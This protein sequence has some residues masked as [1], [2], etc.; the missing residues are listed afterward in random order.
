MKNAATDK[1]RPIQILSYY[2]IISDQ[3][4]NPK[5]LPLCS[6]PAIHLILLLASILNLK[7]HKVD[8]TQAFPHS[9]LID[10][11]HM[12]IP[13]GYRIRQCNSPC[14]KYCLSSMHLK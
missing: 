6:W 4:S 7:S 3:N 13:Q 9:P 8:Y 14:M 10:L 11:V 1:C 5:A 2:A 12:C